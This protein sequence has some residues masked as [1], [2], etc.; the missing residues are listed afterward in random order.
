MPFGAKS[1]GG[2][3][4]SNDYAVWRAHFRA[5]LGVGSCSALPS[6]EPLPAAVPEPTNVILMILAAAGWSL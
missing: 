4:A 2:I 5:S 1:P 6:A 3:Y